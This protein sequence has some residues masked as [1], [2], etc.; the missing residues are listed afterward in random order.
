MKDRATLFD[1]GV[2][3]LLLRAPGAVETFMLLRQ[4]G[5]YRG[6]GDNEGQRKRAHETGLAVVLRNHQSHCCDMVVWNGR[7]LERMTAFVQ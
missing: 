5:C 6:E 2:R 4:G 3:A 7:F 1:W